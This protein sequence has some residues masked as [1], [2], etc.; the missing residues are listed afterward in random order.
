MESSA[1]PDSELLPLK[2]TTNL[3]ILVHAYSSSGPCPP[4]TSSLAILCVVYIG[5]NIV[6]IIL[7]GYDNDLYPAPG[8]VVPSVL[9]HKLE[10]VAGSRSST[11]A[12]GCAHRGG[13]MVRDGCRAGWL[14]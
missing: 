11:S 7:N 2:S 6:C 5:V 14:S 1:D 8:S 3:L 12:L 13:G 10:Y 4:S 9:F